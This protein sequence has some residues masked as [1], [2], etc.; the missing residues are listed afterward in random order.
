MLL[1]AAVASAK[2]YAAA[3][4]LLVSSDLAV[5][6]IDVA[7]MVMLLALIAW[8]EVNRPAVVACAMLC[9]AAIIAPCA[10]ANF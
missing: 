3:L 9:C 6:I 1:I 5:L 4:A 7:E 2:S 10:Y 8:A